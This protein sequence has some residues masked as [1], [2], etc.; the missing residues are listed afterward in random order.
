MF[1]GYD[2]AA[3]AVVLLCRSPAM[4]LVSY[5]AMIVWQVLFLRREERVLVKRFR[6]EYPMYKRRVPFLWPWF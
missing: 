2:C 4:L 3:L 5:P 1:L 6:D